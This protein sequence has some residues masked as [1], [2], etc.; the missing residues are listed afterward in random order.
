[1]SEVQLEIIFRADKAGSTKGVLTAKHGDEVLHA[2]RMDIAKDRQRS[3]FVSKLKERCPS[4][5]TEEVQQLMLDEVHR[6]AQASSPPQ[7]GPPAE[8]DVSRIVRPHLFHVPE[9][10]G[11]LIPVVQARGNERPE[12]KWLLCVQWA[13]GRRECVDLGDYLDLGG[14]ERIWFNPVPPAPLPS[15]ISRWS[16]GSRGKWLKEGY[17]PNLGKLFVRVADRFC[18]FLEFPPGDVL[19]TVYTLSLWTM[20]TYVYPVWSA[21]PYLSVGGPLGSGKSRLFQVLGLL[22]HSP[23]HSSNITAPSLFRT[24]HCQGGTVLLDEAERLS[25]RT[26]DAAEIR[27]ILLAGYQR[28]GQATRLERIDDNFRSVSFD[29]YGPKASAAISSMPAALASRCIRVMMFRAGK[30]SPVP[31]RRID[32]ATS[33]WTGLRDDLHC[34]AL[35]HGASFVAMAG[36]Q[37]TCAGLN[38]RDLELWLPILAMA[39]LIENAGM[40]GLV[41]AVEQH[42]L[43]SVESSQEDIVPEMDEVLLRTLKQMLEDKPYGVTAGDVLEA[44]SMDEHSLFSHYT[45]RGVA[46]VFKRYGIQSRPSGGK[47]YLKSDEKQWQAIE[48]SYNIDFALK[49]PGEGTDG[50]K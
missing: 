50:N 35:S 22:V 42:A 7:F 21:V 48:A 33:E 23:I 47:R 6:A 10:S 13:D 5:N 43:K 49:G 30:S 39:K 34:M 24:L 1:M 20:L 8:L 11:L 4:V 45:P 27:S 38:G 46:A 31:K 28:G 16:S 14:D 25:D 37:P 18:N 36:W 2:D 9:A 29:V 26:P 40:E 17:T 41:E 19:G 32:P 44:A 3:A 15:T 12:G